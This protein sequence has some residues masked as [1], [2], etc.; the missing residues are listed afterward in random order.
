MSFLLLEFLVASIVAGRAVVVLATLRAMSPPIVP[1]PAIALLPVHVAL[2]IRP[3]GSACRDA[4]ARALER[5][6]QGAVHKGLRK[7]VSVWEKPAA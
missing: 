6:E 5:V 4:T 3:D 1:S 2:G 7:H